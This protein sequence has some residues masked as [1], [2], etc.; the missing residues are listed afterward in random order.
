MHQIDI[1]C[2]VRKESDYKDLLYIVLLYISATTYFYT[3]QKITN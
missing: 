1:M 2:G 3:N